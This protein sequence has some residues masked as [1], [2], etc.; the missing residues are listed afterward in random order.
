MSAPHAFVVYGPSHIAVLVVFVAGAVA[1]VV[2]ARRYRDTKG[3]RWAE[4]VAAL[5]I[6][7][8][9]LGIAIYSVATASTGVV[10]ALPLQ[11]SDL[12][13]LSAAYALASRRPWACTMTYYW[14]VAL[15]TETLISPEYHGI[16]FP[17]KGFLAF[18]GIHLLVMWTAIYLT[19]G[20]GIHPDWGRYRATVAVTFG[21]VIVAMTV[22]G[23]TGSNYGFLNRKPQTASILD[24]F[25]PWPWYVLVVI[26]IVAAVWAL[27]T[28]PWVRSRTTDDRRSSVD[29]PA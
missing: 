8:L 18:W 2:L 22:N 28:W 29:Q 11:L 12:V 23:L 15:S 5:A 27:M 13:A 14:G 10:Y 17:D 21:W 6:F 25:G 9:W 24:F 1:A 20:V 4:R 16:D 7:A 3:A 19:W 26:V